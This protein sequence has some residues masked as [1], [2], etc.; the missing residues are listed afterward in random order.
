MSL[1]QLVPQMTSWL[2]LAKKPEHMHRFEPLV[3]L[4]VPHIVARVCGPASPGL[5]CDY[6]VTGY[7]CELE[8]VCP[9]KVGFKFKLYQ[10]CGAAKQGTEKE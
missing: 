5:L 8:L 1:P 6:C 9:H 2:R 7:L 10:R 3:E 4:V